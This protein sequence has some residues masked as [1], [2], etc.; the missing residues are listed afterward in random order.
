MFGNLCRQVIGA[1]Q[2]FHGQLCLVP[3]DDGRCFLY[4]LIQPYEL[5]VLVVFLIEILQKMVEFAIAIFKFQ[6]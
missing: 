5:T 1:H 3:P 6:P 4:W 2:F